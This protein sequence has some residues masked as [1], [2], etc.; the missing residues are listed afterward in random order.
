MYSL[1]PIP[2]YEFVIPNVI[3][4]ETNE[5]LVDISEYKSS[6]IILDFAYHRI[7]VPYSINK[8]LMR[9]RVAEKLIKASAELPNGLCFKIFDAWRPFEV[10]QSLFSQYRQKV[11]HQNPL[12]EDEEID[13][14]TQKFVSKPQKEYENSPVHSTGGAIDLTLTTS[15]GTEL[16]MGTEF[17]DFSL[18][19]YT[20]YYEDEK[21]GEVEIRNNRRIL[22]N[23]MI[24]EGFTNLPTEWWHF[25]YGDKFWAYYT[26]N[27]AFYSGIF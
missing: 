9:K 4:R 16:R 1:K 22:Y 21:N 19:A 8:C 6:R 20:A 27:I 15:D 12:M 24:A 3:T 23:A 14:L 18:K 10:Q 2:R 5:E 11:K 25:D 26:D 13:F 7:G 17:D